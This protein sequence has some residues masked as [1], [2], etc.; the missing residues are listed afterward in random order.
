M[1]SAMAKE[2]VNII[3]QK[4]VE[5]ELPGDYLDDCMGTWEMIAT[6][7]EKL[8]ELWNSDAN[9][10]AWVAFTKLFPDVQ[11]NVW[12]YSENN[13]SAQSN[14]APVMVAKMICISINGSQSYS[15]LSLS[16]SLSV[17]SVLLSNQAFSPHYDVLVPNDVK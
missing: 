15:P 4:K 1:V 12:Q 16:P 3:N 5:K 14:S 13:S 7:P 11:V 8:K 2:A 17:C 6:N 9:D 10:F